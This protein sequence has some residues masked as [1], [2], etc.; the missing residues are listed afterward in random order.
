M[1]T[2]KV[3]VIIENGE[4]T[5]VY[6]NTAAP[7]MVEFIDINED[8][9]SEDGSVVVKAIEDDPN[10]SPVEQYSVRNCYAGEEDA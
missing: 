7:V 10:F 4:V 3:K 5:A 1:D 6:A 2:V 8:F 9:G